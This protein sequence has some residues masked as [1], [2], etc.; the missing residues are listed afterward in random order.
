VTIEKFDYK[1][2]FDSHWEKLPPK[3]K[4]SLVTLLAVIAGI[5]VLYIAVSKTPPKKPPH[6]AK[7]MRNIFGQKEM[8]QQFAVGQVSSQLE[9]MLKENKDL[10]DKLEPW[11]NA[12]SFSYVVWQNLLANLPRQT[13]PTFPRLSKTPHGK[14]ANRWP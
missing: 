7:T 8:A 11:M 12:K 4:K 13:R 9:Q 1:A 3:Y 2:W 5:G 10:R 14:W 6:E